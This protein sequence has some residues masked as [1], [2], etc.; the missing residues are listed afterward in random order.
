MQGMKI[1]LAQAKDSLSQLVRVAQ[2]GEDVIL[3]EDGKPVARLLAFPTK[4]VLCVDANDP[5][6]AKFGLDGDPVPIP[7]DFDDPAFGRSALGLAD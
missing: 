6:R 1:T 4:R 2:D 7:A 3:V 5:D